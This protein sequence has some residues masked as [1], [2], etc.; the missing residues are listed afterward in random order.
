MHLVDVTAKRLTQRG[1][2]LPKNTTT[3]VLVAAVD[4]DSPA[5]LAGILPGDVLLQVQKTILIGVDDLLKTV[6]NREVVLISCGRGQ[7]RYL[8]AVA[9]RVQPG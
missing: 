5:D 3:G 1:I 6:E 9:N 7:N 2:A 8:A 4:P